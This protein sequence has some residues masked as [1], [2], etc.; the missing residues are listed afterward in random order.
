M[1]EDETR[2]KHLVFFMFNNR[3]SSTVVPDFDFVVNTE[4]IQTATEI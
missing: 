3:D 4:R 1:S 2:N